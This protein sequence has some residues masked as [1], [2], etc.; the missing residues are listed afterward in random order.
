MDIPTVTMTLTDT[1]CKNAKPGEKIR[2]LSDGGGLQ[3]WVQ[4]TGSRQWRFAYRFG[5]KQ[6]ALAIGP[7]PTVGLAD[8]REIQRTAKQHLAKGLDPSFVKRET[9]TKQAADALTF[10]AIAKEFEEKARREGRAA[11]TM[12]KLTWLLRLANSDIGS[13]PIVDITPA[14]ILVP[15]RRVEAKGHY[16]TARRLRSTIGTIFRY[17]VATARAE[18]DPTASLQGA[19]TAPKVTPR[20]AI[21]DPAELG[22]FLRAIDTY[23]GQPTTKTG[24]MLMAYLF[25]RPGELRQAEW[26]EF[27]LE[28]AIW[29]I[30]AE[31]MKMRR[32]HRV[33][34]AKQAISYLKALKPLTEGSD[35]VLPSIRSNSRPMS[36]AGMTAALRHMGYPREK[37]VPH[38]F[39]ATAS[40]LLNESG[41]WHPDA[42]ERQLAHIEANEVRRAY[43]RSEHW[44]ER[45][46]MMSWWAGYLDELRLS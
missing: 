27:D 9:K 42:I 2:K 21:T 10:R 3:L 28:K 41:K 12:S 33:P 46:E 16:E 35:L 40:T 37:V 43:A 24:L 7:Y 34:L 44:D 20:A 32:P 17:A 15:L 6:K 30:P 29:S 26:C 23:D 11:S 36:N 18:N 4:P 22:A 8:A 39:R 13:R 25:P 19:L 5:G 14:E 31:R 45:V 38:G 1:A